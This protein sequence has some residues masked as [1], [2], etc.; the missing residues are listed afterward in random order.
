MAGWKPIEQ[1]EP[2][3]LRDL[4]T[5]KFSLTKAAETTLERLRTTKALAGVASRLEHH[6]IE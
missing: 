3:A 5:P 2:F 4:Q 1:L 6:A